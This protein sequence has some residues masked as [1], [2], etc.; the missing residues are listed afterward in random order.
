M[1]RTIPSG[2]AY[3]LNFIYRTETSVAPKCYETIY[4]NNQVKLAKPI[5]K[6]TVDEILTAQP[7]WTKKFKSSATGAAQFMYLTLLGLK[8]ELGLTGS[9]TF[10]PDLQDRLAYHLLKR[11][12]YQEFVTGKISRTE[13]GKR[14][15][16]EW[17]SFPVLAVTQGASRALQRGQS[18]YAG[19]ALNKSLVS[20]AGV[21][22][23]LDQ[24]LVL[25]N[26][27]IL[28]TAPIVVPKVEP[29]ISGKAV[30]GAIAIVGGSTALALW[31]WLTTMPCN[32]LGLFCGN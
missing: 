24:V 11:R 12:G 1:D 13:F 19:D 3:L 29:V 32:V 10:T 27:I 14:L 25:A 31:P 30:T 23:V 15:A 9:E 20:A 8:K 28:P 21:E 4:G 26:P 2:A 22:T 16:Q 6:M 18:Y 17:A 5:T 7:G